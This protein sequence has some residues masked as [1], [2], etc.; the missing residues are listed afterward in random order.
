MTYLQETA[1]TAMNSYHYEAAILGKALDSLGGMDGLKIMVNAKNFQID[2][3]SVDFELG[4]DQ[5][6]LCTITTTF[7]YY[8]LRLRH[9]PLSSLYNIDNR[10]L[11]LDLQGVKR[12]FEKT[13]NLK[14]D[15]N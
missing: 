7:N 5:K 4:F 2:S 14:L 9:L 3:N 13:T 11:C 10:V 15:Y 8:L 1:M 6:W 12:N